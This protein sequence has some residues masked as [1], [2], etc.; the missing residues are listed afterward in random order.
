[1]KFKKPIYLLIPCP[2]NAI[3][4]WIDSKTKTQILIDVATPFGIF[5]T[6]IYCIV[7][8]FI[9]QAIS[10]NSYSPIKALFVCLLFYY[11]Q[12][13]YSGMKSIKFKFPQKKVVSMKPN[14]KEE[15]EKVTNFVLQYN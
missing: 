7:P 10:Y 11:G 1:M 12:E 2:M 15:I 9:T 14:N 6:I 5:G 8:A 3:K 4:Q 13:I